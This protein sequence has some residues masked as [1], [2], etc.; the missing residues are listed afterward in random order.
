MA[1]QPAN[2]ENPPPKKKSRRGL[3][4][5][6]LLLLA[7]GGGGAAYKILVL[8][9]T[10]LDPADAPVVIADPVYIELRPAFVINLADSDANRFLQVEVDLMSRDPKAPMHVET[11]MPAIRHQVVMDLS[12]RKY[13]ELRTVEG[14]EAILA[15]IRDRM[16]ALLEKNQQQANVIEDVYFSSF[17]MQ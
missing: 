6:I 8:D 5:G 10:P 14:K 3:I 15:H 12:S 11:H 2:P 13:A 1:E 4:F 17:V 7:A 16:N 9:A